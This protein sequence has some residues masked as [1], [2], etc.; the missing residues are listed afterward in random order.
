MQ[1]IIHPCAA[2][3][4]EQ[5]DI[6]TVSGDTITINDFPYDLS[7]VP[8]GGEA[9]AEGDHPFA[10]LIRREDG[11]LIVPLIVRYDS[12][13]AEPDQPRDWSHWTVTLTGGALPDR[14][15]RKPVEE[16]A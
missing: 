11:E 14:V 13:T 7:A 15:V 3:P 8:D 4:G 12:T 5:D 9:T 2:L 1:I 10:G 6:V 16:G